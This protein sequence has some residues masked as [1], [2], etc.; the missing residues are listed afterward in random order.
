MK[1][2]VVLLLK[3]DISNF[4]AFIWRFFLFVSCWTFP[5]SEWYLGF[6]AYENQ[7]SRCNRDFRVSTVIGKTAGEEFQT[8][9]SPKHST[10]CI[11]NTEAT[12]KSSGSVGN[13]YWHFYKWKMVESEK[14]A[15]VSKKL[16]VIW[17]VIIH[18]RVVFF[19]N[20]TLLRCI[21]SAS[22]DSLGFKKKI[23]SSVSDIWRKPALRMICIIYLVFRASFLP[24]ILSSLIFIR[25]NC[26]VAFS[27]HIQI[28]A[29]S[30]LPSHVKW[31]LY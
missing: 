4:N 1:K 25:K 24:Y 18:C 23:A 6:V 27:V 5:G 13:S 10:F 26:W 14:I 8:V 29:N 11:G 20:L 22:L 3:A 28:R 2:Y 30:C 7:R 17:I 31:T 16:L 19:W 21:V 15:F 12:T 9:S